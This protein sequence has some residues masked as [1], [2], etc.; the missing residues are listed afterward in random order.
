MIVKS[1]IYKLK[2]GR[3][4]VSYYNPASRK[5][6]RKKF[7]LLREAEKF[8]QDINSLLTFNSSNHSSDE[9]VEVWMKRYL[10]LNPKAFIK[11][12]GQPLS[13]S[14]LKRFG[15]VAV[16][17]V[18][19]TALTEWLEGF[20]RSRALSVKTMPN[21]K[22]AVNQFFQFIV[23]S[24]ALAVNPMIRVKTGV[25]LPPK[26]RTVLNESEI[27]LLLY[28][29]KLASPDL[30]F[31]VVFLLAQTG[32]RLGE[33]LNLK[34][35]DVH[36]EIGAIQLLGTKNGSDRLIQISDKVLA[37]LGSQPQVNE[38]VVVSQYRIEWTQAQY[39][40]QLDKF[41][42]KIKFDKYWCSHSL[43]HSFASNHLKNGGDMFRLQKTLG[44]TSLQMTVDLYGRID[45]SD[46]VDI[47]PFNF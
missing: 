2:S 16:M 13:D 28:N 39:R 3:Y 19:Q 12:Q 23:D 41:K 47:S 29:L 42:R 34:W 15:S 21:I 40:K 8:K 46:V 37:F 6:I 30:M 38:N 20:Q 32:A 1:K 45:A 43:R 25:G 4:Q 26:D 31:P 14:F 5:R 44:H 7:V 17:S 9:S 27:E 35:K 33:I 22:S 18:E 11:R 24:K 36:F 10:N